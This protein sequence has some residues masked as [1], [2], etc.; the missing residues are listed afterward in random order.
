MNGGVCGRRAFFGR[1]ILQSFGIPT[2]ARPQTGH[3]S[4]VHW[5][6]DGWVI[7]LGGGWGSGLGV[8]GRTDD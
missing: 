4:L 3:A 2:V 1:F 7:C 8:D 6:P 5:T